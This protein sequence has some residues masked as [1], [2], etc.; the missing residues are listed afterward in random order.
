MTAPVG[1]SLTRFNAVTHGI[2][3]RGAVLPW[4]NR[5]EYEA[6]AAA[7]AAEHR[8]QGPTEAHLVEEVAG[9]LW[10][11]RRLRLAEA[12]AHQRGLER[13]L[14]PHRGAARAALAHLGKG[15]AAPRAASAFAPDDEDPAE[16][17]RRLDACEA[18]ARAALGQL[19][20]GGTLAAALAAL[21]P[22]VRAAWDAALAEEAEEDDDAPPPDAP[23]LRAF[24]QSQVLGAIRSQRD[25]IAHR[26]QIRAQAA[27]ESLDP[28]KLER[29]AR[30]EVHLDRK[31]ERMLSMLLKL[32]AMRAAD[33]DA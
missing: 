33:D 23:R 24:L 15:V 19:D 17:L 22:E 13:A 18:E 21:D 10:R 27:G 5:D 6:L 9:I 31:L 20:A 3:S 28:D 8:P 26:P 2:L 11:K 14:D 4:E 7:L 1:T 16:Q 30:Y 29:L 12:A 32:K 25:E